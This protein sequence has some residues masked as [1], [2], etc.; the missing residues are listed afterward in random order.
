MSH[1]KRTST[2]TSAST[3]SSIPII[4]ANRVA[5][6][7]QG[8]CYSCGKP[9]HWRSECLATKQLEASEVDNGS[10]HNQQKIS[11]GKFVQ[12]PSKTVKIPGVKHNSQVGCF[13]TC[14][15]P[16]LL[17]FGRLKC[18]IQKW[19]DTNVIS[20]ILDVIKNGKNLPFSSVPSKV[21]LRNN[22]SARNDKNM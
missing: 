22:A 16:M 15:N 1:T 4:G 20:S 19:S 11:T 12:I 6:R 17:P 13:L 8:N 9:G 7:R 18:H 10:R 21:S 2:V 3:M 14:N 5:G